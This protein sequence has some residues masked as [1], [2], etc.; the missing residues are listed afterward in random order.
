MRARLLTLVT[1]LAASIAASFLLTA[2][3]EAAKVANPGGFSATVTDGFLRI[4]QQTFGFDPNNPITFTGSVDSQGNVNIPTAGQVYPPFMIQQS[5]LNL[6]V[7][8]KPAAPITGTINPL[9]G[10]ASLRLRVF[11]KIDGVPFGGDCHIASSASPI[12]VN[13]LITGTTNPPGPNTPITGTPYN[14]S[15]GT[16]KI[17]NNNF[18]VPAATDCGFANGTVNDSLGLPSAAG[19]NEAQFVLRT[20]PILQRAITASLAV[21]GTSG[22]TPYTVDFD[23]SGSTRTAPLRNYQWDFN[24]DGTFDRTTTS[25]TTSFTYTSAGVYPAK[26]RITDTDGD[27]AEATRTITVVDPPDLSID[28]THTDPF[29]V[30]TQGHYDLAVRNVSSGSTTGGTTVTDTL[31]NGLTF[32]GSS[33]S[34]WNCSNVGQ[35]VTCARSGLIPGNASA[36]TIG[37]DVNVTTAAIPGGTNVARVTTAGDSQA[38]NDLDNDPTTVTV[39]DLAIDK[40]HAANFRPGA[41]PRN[42]Y[43]ID[44][45]NPGSAATIAATIVSDTL[46][47][48]LTPTSATGAGWSCSIAGQQVT[49][50]RAASISGG[51]SAPTIAIETSAT[52]PPDTTATVINTASV[53]TTGDAFPANDSDSDPT[54]IADA[55]DLAITK[56][57]QGTFTAGA[58]ATFTIDVL[59]DGPR[60]TSGPIT[61]SDTLPSGLTFAGASGTDWTCSANAQEVTCTRQSPIPGDGDAPSIQL[62]VN[63]GFAAIPSVTNTATVDTDGDDNATNDSSSDIATVRAIDL[64]IDKS[65]TSPLRVGREGVFHLDVSNVGDSTTVAPATIT[66]TLP[67][68][69]SFVSATGNGWSCSD[70]GQDITCSNPDPIASADS[71]PRLDLRV[72]VDSAAIPSVDNTATVATTDDFNPDNDSDTDHANVVEA[73]ASISIARTGAFNSESTGT[74]LISVDNVGSTPTTDSTTVSVTLPTG[75]GF[76]SADGEGWTCS[77]AAGEVTCTRPGPIEPETP[78]PDIALRVSVARD[79]PSPLTTTAIV[80]TTGDRNPDND[81]ASDTATIFGPD[82]TASSTHAGPFQVGSNGN[83]TLSIDNVGGRPTRGTTTVTDSLP[84]GLEFV[85]A[86]G[87]GWDCSATG[88][89]VTCVREAEI[90]AGAT[91]PAIQLTVAV[92]PAAA[93]SVINAVSVSTAGDRDASSDTDNDFTNVLAIDL[94]LQ[95]D[96]DGPLTTGREATYRVSVDNVGT[97]ATSGPARVTDTLP[98]GLTPS[99]AEGAGWDCSSSGQDVTCVHD[100]ILGPGDQAQELTIRAFVGPGSASTVNNTAT[101]STVADADPSNDSDTDQAEV[102]RVPDLELT[103]DDQPP[104]GGA[105]R[106]GGAG[107]YRLTVLNGGGA[108]TTGPASLSVELGNGMTAQSTDG[109]GWACTTSGRN[110]QC[111]YAASIAAGARTDLSIVVDVGKTSGTEATTAASVTTPGDADESDNSASHTSPVTRIDLKAK[112]TY[113][114]PWQADKQSTY[115]LG[116]ANVGSAATVGPVTLTDQLPTGISL[117]SAVGDGWDCR[118]TGSEVVC[119]RDGINAGAQSPD[120]TVTV[121]V[122]EDAFPSATGTATVQTEDDVDPANDSATDTVEVLEADRLSLPA[123][124]VNKRARPTRSGIVYLRV[125]CPDESETDCTGTIS[126]TS[127]KKMKQTG[128][129]KKRQIEFG[130]ASFDATDGHNFLAPIRLSKR[131]QRIINRAGR[132]KATVVV[133]TDGFEPITKKVILRRGR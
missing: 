109:A 79:A 110:V 29:R 33:G 70:V 130:S 80:S 129:K 66:D 27:F 39:I 71:A 118:G 41:D 50:T 87:S 82:L 15:D 42:T 60:P 11:I 36:P 92:R 90:A 1:V 48:E 57:H 115:T 37:I 121:D 123:R 26:M 20:N 68:G 108:P 124:L 52:L 28:S 132:L 101:V 34:G 55:P 93:P 95:L 114:G 102:V 43:E 103:L 38:A 10:A 61:V 100:G 47:A 113:A 119:T 88:Q 16:F 44:V 31:P 40:S 49:C 13:A 85:S 133:A 106:V 89:D 117:V 24:G 14:T 128:G 45:S 83:Y 122:G 5:G 23:A 126:I 63:V 111:E 74:Y 81:T 86:Q 7:T 53:S 19:N 25:P 120:V 4:K 94:R 51:T 56:S 76:L 54:V 75:L 46:P 97:A 72:A 58:Q 8:I 131:N 2:Q 3:A 62:D 112:K 77:E 12:D 78:L 107:S 104:A 98:A 91:A 32:A 17:V 127:T 65:H 69:L 21:S 67:A 59:N 64:T 18:S 35:V 96:R 84:T 125:A 6:T 99:E 105:Y 73:D 22:T 9:T 116:A 30:G